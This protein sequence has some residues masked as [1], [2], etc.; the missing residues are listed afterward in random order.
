MVF[1]GAG[2]QNQMV[3][4]EAQEL[5]KLLDVDVTSCLKLGIWKI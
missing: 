5:N 3:F 1:K 4:K 2:C